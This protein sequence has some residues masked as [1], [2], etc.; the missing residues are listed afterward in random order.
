MRQPAIVRQYLWHVRAV[1]ER[2][3][4]ARASAWLMRGCLRR[5]RG[6]QIRSAF[7][8]NSLK[9]DLKVWV[10]EREQQPA[11]FPRYKHPLHLS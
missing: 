1:N 5:M 6:S 9:T 2:K 8:A 7:A 4:N 10:L 3:L 11:L